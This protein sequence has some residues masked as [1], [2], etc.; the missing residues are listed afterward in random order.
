VRG[1]FA[2]KARPKTASARLLAC[3]ISGATVDAVL[4]DEEAMVV[5]VKRLTMT[6]ALSIAQGAIEACRRQG[7]QITATVVDRDGNAQVVLRETIAA[8][9]TLTISQ[10]KAYTAAN[11]NAAT[12]ALLDRAG[13]PLG[14]VTGVMMWAGGVPIQA[15]GSLLGAIGVS[16]APSEATDEQCAQA[17]ID[18][19]QDDLEMSM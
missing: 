9:L 10:Q 18:A 15:G 14:R 3:L 8:P 12:S 5:P 13:T 16:G 2:D 19:V 1:L 17:G 4:A 11:F 7:I 6:T